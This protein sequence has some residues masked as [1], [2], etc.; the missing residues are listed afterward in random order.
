MFG[1]PHLTMENKERFSLLLLEP[2]EYY[3]EDYIASISITKNDTWLNGRL[4]VCSLSL[5]FDPKDYHKPILKIPF[6]Q[7]GSITKS[8]DEDS[9]ILNI[10]CKQYI[11]MLDHNV[12]EPYKFIN[13]LSLFRIDLKY[14]RVEDCLSLILQLHRASSLQTAEHRH[15]AAAIAYGRQTLIKFDP[16]WLE[17]GENIIM[18][19][20]GQKITPL[21]INSGRI[22]LTSLHVY[23]QPFNNNEVTLYLKIELSEIKRIIKRRFLLQ[24]VQQLDL[25]WHNFTL[26]NLIFKIIL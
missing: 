4:K 15:M 25:T 13:E 5:V 7:C 9:N 26:T 12:L 24:Q 1:F 10:I 22:V 14:A 17:L 2:G 3:F 23:F 16:T 8:S 20:V 21:S 11:E 18:E 19:E 6:T